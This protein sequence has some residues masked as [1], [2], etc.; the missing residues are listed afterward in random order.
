MPRRFFAR[1]ERVEAACHV[2]DQINA[3]MIA[4]RVNLVNMF[5][6]THD[7]YVAATGCLRARRQAGREI[8]FVAQTEST[9]R[10]RIPDY[11]I[12]SYRTE[13]TYD[14]PKCFPPANLSLGFLAH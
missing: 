12:R 6:L 8:Q 4:A 13:A 2:R 5:D 9:E 1:A 3:A 10:G 11:T 7:V 14:D